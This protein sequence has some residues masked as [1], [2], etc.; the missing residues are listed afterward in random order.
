MRIFCFL[1]L[2]VTLPLFALESGTALKLTGEARAELTYGIIDSFDQDDAVAHQGVYGGGTYLYLDGLAGDQDFAKV[3]FLLVAGYRYADSNNMSDT[4]PEPVFEAKKLFLSVY[5]SHADISVGRMIL[6]YGRG[7]VLSPAD[8]F[9]TIDVTDPEL[10]RIGTN[11]VRIL[12]PLGAVS[13]IELLSTIAEKPE[14]G[15]S[16]LRL[17]SNYSGWD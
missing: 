4:T 10:G 3:D 7:T 12:V 1:L 6:N 14:N 5:T 9:S 8:L 16:G 13:G 17:Y 2:F 15:I 11:A